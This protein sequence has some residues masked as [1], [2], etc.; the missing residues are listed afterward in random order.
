M[1]LSALFTA[2]L[3]V[4][5]IQSAAE[6][7]TTIIIGS[8]GSGY[9]TQAWWYLGDGNEFN[10]ENI[11]KYWDQD[12]YITSASYTSHGWFL[13]ASLGTVWT[14]QGYKLSSAWPSDWVQ[15]KWSDGFY[16]TSLAASESQYFLVAS[17]GTSIKSQKI[18]SNPDW[19]VIREWMQSWWKESYVV[20]DMCCKNGM[21]TFLMNYTGEYYQQTVFWAN[22][23]DDIG[24]QIKDYWDKDYRITALQYGGGEFCCVMSKPEGA[25]NIGQGYFI[26]VTDSPKDYINEL[27]E[28]GRSITYIG[29]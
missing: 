10:N 23:A 6:S 15:S 26:K 19:S 22:S 9:T 4:C 27:W 3:S 29:G 5:A 18:C 20:A 21:W 16:I 24:K 7:A 28:E 11:R 2:L 17:E 12:Y 8:S 13:A 1:K 25:S 14:D